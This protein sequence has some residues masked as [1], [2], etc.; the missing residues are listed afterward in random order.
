ML[1][2]LVKEKKGGR[3]ISI[4]KKSTMQLLHNSTHSWSKCFVFFSLSPWHQ[5]SQEVLPHHWGAQTLPRSERRLYCTRRNPCDAPGLDGKQWTERLCKEECPGIQ[6]LLDRC[7]RHSERR[8]VCRCQQSASQLLQLGPF[9]EAAHRNEEGELCCS[10]SGLTRQVVR[11]GVSQPQEV[12]L[13]ICHSLKET[14][15]C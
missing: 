6:G 11:R 3:F 7:G 2:F 1:V 10:L 4:K 14:D 8:P 15:G 5:S 9:Q 12:H 13:R